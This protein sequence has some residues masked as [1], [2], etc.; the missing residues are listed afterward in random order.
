MS[1]FIKI[2][3]GIVMGRIRVSLSEVNPVGLNHN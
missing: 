1:K 2:L 3:R